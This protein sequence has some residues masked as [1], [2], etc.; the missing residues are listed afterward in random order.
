M[1]IKFDLGHDLERWGV[2]IYRIVM[3]VASDV[4]LSNFYYVFLSIKS[5][6]YIDFNI[7][8]MKLNMKML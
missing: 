2:K 7:K 4:N 6:L 8:N 1:T 5:V 3:G